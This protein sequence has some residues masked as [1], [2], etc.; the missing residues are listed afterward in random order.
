LSAYTIERV[1]SG[2]KTAKTDLSVLDAEGKLALLG[3]DFGD[4]TFFWLPLPLAA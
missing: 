4:R 1:K 3:R 2:F